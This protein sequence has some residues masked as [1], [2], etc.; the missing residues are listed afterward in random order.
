M[1]NKLLSLAPFLLIA[2]L[3][4]CGVEERPINKKWEEVQIRNI[5]RCEQSGGY[6]I[7]SV[8]DSR[9]TECQSI[10]K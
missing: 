7:K 9:M 1:K 6:P 3:I 4:G 8:W 10:R 2:V 5:E